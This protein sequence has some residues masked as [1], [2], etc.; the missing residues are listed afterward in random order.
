MRTDNHYDIIIIGG[1]ASG[2]CTAVMA[3]NKRNRVLIIEHND[4]VGK[5]IL[6]TGN[7]KCNLTNLYCKTQAADPSFTRRFSADCEEISPDVYTEGELRKQFI[8]NPEGIRPYYSSCMNGFAETVI[9]AFD[10]ERTISFFERLG[11]IL[12][13]KNGYVYPRSEQASSVSD[14]LRLKCGESGVDILYGYQPVKVIKNEVFVIDGE[15]SGDCLV[16]ATGGQNA[17]KTGSDGSGY[18]LAKSFGHT[19]I[20]PVPGL[21]ALKCS[22]PFFKELTGVHRCGTFLV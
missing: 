4:R 18:E 2:L 21:C 3:K 16:L 13:N 11:M 9:S 6:S 15:Y 8:E 1:G 20:K 12:L 19:V 7:G 17:S 22:E 14:L 5:K 10:A